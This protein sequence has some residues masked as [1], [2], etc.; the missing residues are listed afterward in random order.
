MF[1]LF[2][3]YPYFLF[4]YLFR[5]PFS[6]FTCFL[7]GVF[8][9]SLCSPFSFY[10]LPFWVLYGITFH[11]YLFWSWFSLLFFNSLSFLWFI[12]WAFSLVLDVA[13]LSISVLFLV[14]MFIFF[15]LLVFFTLLFSVVAI[16]LTILV[17]VLVLSCTFR[18]LSSFVLVVFSVSII[19]PRSISLCSPS[20]SSSGPQHWSVVWCFHS[21]WFRQNSFC[22]LTVPRLS[23]RSYIFFDYFI[24]L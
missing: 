13:I 7:P 23:Y 17:F 6:L 16:L 10:C 14:L 19:G 22:I 11:L 1:L 18:S 24:N 5:P 4:H 9:V 3:S 21:G 15:I 2:I 8:H 20:L 12:F